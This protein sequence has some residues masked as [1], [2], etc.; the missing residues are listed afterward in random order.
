MVKAIL[1]LALLAS[2]FALALSADFYKSCI[3]DVFMALVLA[4]GLVTLSVIQMCI[5]D[6][7]CQRGT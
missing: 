4:A 7:L 1:T 3:V 5:R 6:S 2:V